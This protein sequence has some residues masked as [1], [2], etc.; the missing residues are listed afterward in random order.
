MSIKEVFQPNSLFH[1]IL[2]QYNSSKITHENCSKFNDTE[3]NKVVSYFFS[4]VP[5]ST[6]PS[7]QSIQKLLV[8]CT[9]QS[10]LEILSVLAKNILT[11]PHLI[12]KNETIQKMEGLDRSLVTFLICG[13]DAKIIEQ[14][15]DLKEINPNPYVFFAVEN[16]QEVMLKTLKTLGANLNA[17]RKNDGATPA[18]IAAY[19]GQVNMLKALDQL[20]ADLSLTNKFQETL[21]HMAACKGHIDVLEFLQE[22]NIFKHPNS[23]ACR[24][25]TPAH[26][27]ASISIVKDKTE[28]NRELKVLEALDNIG[29]GLNLT[30]MNDEGYAPIHT[31]VID[32]NEAMIHALIELEAN[33]NLRSGRGKTP[34][35]YAAASWQI[36]TLKILH[37]HGANLNL[38]DHQRQTPYRVAQHG[39]DSNLK[40]SEKQRKNET[41]QFLEHLRADE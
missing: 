40:P 12:L 13:I 8:K 17:R 5:E 30:I 10:G 27:V 21:L 24:G 2:L 34:A 9:P 14:K 22:I 15:F 16:E 28:T 29:T 7:F 33:L 20:G 31:A 1:N 23:Q 25:Y 11:T 36:T 3:Y 32:R 39:D 26:Y 18:H 37:D 38:E 6:N 4:S 35:H 19:K 41:L